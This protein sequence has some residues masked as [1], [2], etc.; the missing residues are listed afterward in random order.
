MPIRYTFVSDQQGTKIVNSAMK[1]IF[2]IILVMLI[3]CAA[4]AQAPY[5]KS[6]V[7]VLDAGH[8]GK[9]P[10]AVGK[11]SHEKDIA[12]NIVLKTGEYIQK[13]FK[14]VEIVYTRSTDRFVELYRRAEIANQANADLFISVHCNANSRTSPNG[15]EVFVM[16][17]NKTEANLQ[18]A[19]KENNSVLL[20]DDHTENYDG[21][22]PNSSEAY[23]TFSLYTNMH[24]DL[25]LLMAQKTMEAFNTHV[26]RADRGIK[27]A[28]FFVL[29]KTT[30]PSI[31]IE[32]AFISNYED[33]T[34]LM[35]AE[36]QNSM[37]YSIYK[38]FVEYRNSVDGSNYQPM[39]MGNASQSTGSSSSSGT[40]AS[41]E[42]IVF[43]VQF[44]SF[45]EIFSA[46]DPRFSGMTDVHYVKDGSYFKY[47]C[48]T[49]ASYSKAKE[50]LTKAQSNG[51]KDAFLVAY[52]NGKRISVS[53]ARRISGQ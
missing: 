42:D 43:K 14:D 4:F 47:M 40:S 13:H 6:W 45:K 8:G 39:Q 3:S 21:I 25:S 18:V 9:D 35:S 51:Y 28:P 30:M 37:A 46:D 33:E 20:E 32:T 10:G 49:N 1:R 26:K 16:G 41:A 50:E 27:Q 34:Y 24:L 29:Y 12:L 44:A 36:G 7:V 52:Q 38:A 5:Q 17:L 2:F 31:L 48:G 11:R 15:T 22:D 19:I 53:E 23:I